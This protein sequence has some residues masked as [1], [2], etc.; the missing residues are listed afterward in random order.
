MI[1]LYPSK[2]E[3]QPF[4]RHKTDRVMTIESWLMAKVTG[5]AK[6]LP[7]TGASSK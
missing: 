6:A 1:E 3:G 7:A 4:E 2:L 5:F